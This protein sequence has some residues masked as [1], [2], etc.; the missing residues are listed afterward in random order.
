M[1]KAL[2]ETYAYVQLRRKRPAANPLE[3]VDHEDVLCEVFYRLTKKYP[4]KYVPPLCVR[5]R[6]G[7]DV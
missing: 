2:S 5:C 6:L 4:N 1:W 7:A 3:P